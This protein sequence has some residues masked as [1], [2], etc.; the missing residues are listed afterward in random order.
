[1][2]AYGNLD[3]TFG[4]SQGYNWLINTIL[5]FSEG[6]EEMTFWCLVAVMTEYD[7]RGFYEEGTPKTKRLTA[8]MPELL[9]GWI[10]KVV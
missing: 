1:L 8:Q 7:C 4:Y 5:Y 9:K 10:P 6:N 3:L 2:I